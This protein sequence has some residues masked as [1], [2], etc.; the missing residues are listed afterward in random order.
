MPSYLLDTD[1]IIDALSGKRGA[2][3][4]FRRLL[5]EG[6]SLACC[7]VNLAEVFA[8]VRRAEERR[9]SRFLGSLEYYPITRAAA[10]RAGLLK[11]DWAR[12][13]VALSTTDTMI[14]AVALEYNLTLVT[15]NVRHYP[16]PE[17][18]L[19]PTT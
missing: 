10:C 4:L 16:M 7:A 9:V 5:L 8:G 15:R 1:V 12:K 19:Q 17:L 11:R 13:G 3:D 18:R 6:H 2:A 14:A